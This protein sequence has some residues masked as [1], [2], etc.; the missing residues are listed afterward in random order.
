MYKCPIYWITGVPCP[1]CGMTRALVSLLRGDI[2]GAFFMHPLIFVM[3]V[4]LLLFIFGSKKVRSRA[5]VVMIA[6]F[7]TVYAIRMV[8]YFPE[9]KPMVYNHSSVLYTA[10]NIIKNLF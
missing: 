9:S 2:Q 7:L 6:V 10:I 1:G 4:F 3:P 5:S 8:M